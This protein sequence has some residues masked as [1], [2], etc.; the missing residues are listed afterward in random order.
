[1]EREFAPV[2]IIAASTEKMNIAKRHLLEKTSN[3]ETDMG[4]AKAGKRSKLQSPH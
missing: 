4:A 1:M 2:G 3:G